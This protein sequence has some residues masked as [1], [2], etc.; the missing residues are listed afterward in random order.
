MTPRGSLRYRFGIGSVMIALVLVSVALSRIIRRSP[1]QKPVAQM[2]TGGTLGGSF[3]AGSSMGGFSSMGGLLGGQGGST[4]T[5]SSQAGGDAGAMSGPGGNF[6]GLGGSSQ[7]QV[8]SSQAGGDIGIGDFGGF[9]GSSVMGGGSSTAGM[10][11]SQAQQSSQLQQQ[12]SAAQP[13]PA[14]KASSSAPASSAAAPSSVSPPASSSPGIS[15]P[16]PPPSSAAASSALPPRC[17]DGRVDFGET[18]D[19][20]APSGRS[21]TD[22]NCNAICS[23]GRCGDGFTDRRR[24]EECDYVGLLVD[25]TQSPLTTRDESTFARCVS[26][27]ACGGGYCLY[28]HCW[29]LQW[30]S[31]WGWTDNATCPQHWQRVTADGGATPSIGAPCNDFGD[32]RCREFLGDGCTVSCKLERCGDNVVQ[33][34]TITPEG[35]HY[36]LSEECDDGN[37]LSGDGCSERCTV[38]KRP[39][40]SSQATSAASSIAFCDQFPQLCAATSS[41]RGFSFDYSVPPFPPPA[42]QAPVPSSS[43]SAISSAPAVVARVQA[44]GDGR[45]DSGEECDN[46]FANSDA[47]A[48]ACRANCRKASCGDFIADYMLGEQCDQGV[49]N[50]AVDPNRCRPGCTLPTCGDGVTDKGETC[51]DGNTIH[52][53]GCSGSCVWETI[54][55]IQP[56]CGDQRMQG[57]EQCDDGNVTGGDGCSAACQVEFVLGVREEVNPVLVA[58]GIICGDGVLL[59]PEECDDG[60]PEPGDG[61]SPLCKKEMSLCGNGIIEAG[62]ECDPPGRG[63]TDDGSGDDVDT[64]S[65]LCRTIVPKPAAPPPPLPPPAVAQVISQPV[66]YS[67][68]PMRAPI[69]D[70]GPAAIAVMA[71][72]AAAGVGWMRRRR[73]KKA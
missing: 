22:A 66:A 5:F 63:R 43:A 72:G 48:G 50:S 40:A 27:S 61:C 38:E 26:D 44:C 2:T 68:I 64:C 47:M 45:L 46:G 6:G 32:P 33:A 19:L 17:G 49:G 54:D 31:Y 57:S 59:E 60:N 15:P 30:L 71:S 67:F 23:A 39:I 7:A 62:E 4:G 51:D 25:E 58:G 1:I 55:V 13:S 56:W 65:A 53:D 73:K 35:R 70:T 37:I 41:M 52:G 34:G 20:C 69:G 18:C 14:S 36:G 10:Q 29:P 42:S 24:G 9:G 21:A 16:P 28:N 8:G 12:S 3:A 11:S